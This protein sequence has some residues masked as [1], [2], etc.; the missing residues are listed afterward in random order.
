[1]ASAG[2]FV[3]V[4]TVPGRSKFFHVRDRPRRKKA[5]GKLVAKVSNYELTLAKAQVL[6]RKKGQQPM[7]FASGWL[8]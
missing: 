8:V 2:S 1:M 5:K 3:G 6:A 4:R 7:T